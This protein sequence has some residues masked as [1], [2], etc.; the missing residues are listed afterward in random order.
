MKLDNVKLVLTKYRFSKFQLIIGKDKPV[1]IANEMITG[2][3]INED[4]DNEY[5]PFFCVELALSNDLYRKIT[6]T[7]S[8]GVKANVRLEKGVFKDAVSANTSKTHTFKKVFD[9]KFVVV[10]PDR[11]PD[12]TEV[13]QKKTEKSNNQYGQLTSL[14][15]LLYSKDFYNKYDLV[16][17]DVLSNV[18]LADTVAYILN[19]V[20][21]KNI[22]MSPPSNT[23]KYQQFIIT[24]IPVC[25]Q[26]DRLANTY[27]MHAKG[28]VVYFGIKTGYIVSKEQNC[29]AW[30]SGENKITYIGVASS[31]STPSVGGGYSSSTGKY[32]LLNA[33]DITSSNNNEVTKHTAGNNVVIVNNMGNVTKTSKNTK[34]TTSVITQNEGDNTAAALKNMIREN[35]QV[36]TVSLS[37]EDIDAL[38]PNKEFVMTFDSAKY[39]RYNGKYR[40]TKATHTF[41]K[42]GDYFSVT[43][44]AEFK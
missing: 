21:M 26:L 32:F 30:K 17:N 36:I 18:T 37:N 35:K 29:T 25:E 22:L 3:V 41:S 39:K 27:A 23:K 16:V 19:K 12:M 34:K 43:T 14:S 38:T 5:L 11:T 6:K 20:G 15:I 1:D 28:T 42:E 13:I 7:K 44:T 8:D 4:F 10:Y 33:S 40:L 9:G 2:F 24:P 31:E